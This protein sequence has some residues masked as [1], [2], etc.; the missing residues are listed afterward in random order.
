LSSF[1]PFHFSRVQS[2][3]SIIPTF[4]NVFDVVFEWFGRI[5]TKISA[6]SCISHMDS[7]VEETTISNSSIRQMFDG[8]F[9]SCVVNVN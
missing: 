3:I 6:Q 9:A 1:L 8:N 7:W 5:V 2:A 4:A